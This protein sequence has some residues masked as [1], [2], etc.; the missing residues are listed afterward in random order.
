MPQEN[1]GIMLFH[2]ADM[3]LFDLKDEEEFAFCRKAFVKR[4]P[5]RSEGTSD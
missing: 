2:M 4:K 3:I 1:L 5:L